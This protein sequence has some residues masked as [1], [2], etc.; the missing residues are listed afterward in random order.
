[1]HSNHPTQ[2]GYQYVKEPNMILLCSKGKVMCKT[3]QQQDSL[4]SVSVCFNTTE[5]KSLVV[6]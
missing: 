1:M 6:H 4:F 2:Y 5:F 3:E